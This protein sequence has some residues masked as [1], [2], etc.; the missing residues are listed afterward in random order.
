MGVV[1]PGDFKVVH[2][3]RFFALNVFVLMR[4]HCTFSSPSPEP[5]TEPHCMLYTYGILS[6]WDIELSSDSGS[7]EDSN[8][9][10]AFTIKEVMTNFWRLR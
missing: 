10:S 4:F 8:D 5:S 6:L 7:C 1:I 3:K 2:S 9:V